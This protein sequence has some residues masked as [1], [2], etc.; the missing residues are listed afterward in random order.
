MKL[1]RKTEIIPYLRMGF[2]AEEVAKKFERSK[3]T[4]ERWIKEL[5]EDGVEVKTIGRGRQ[6]I[7]N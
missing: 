4:V 2:T 1:Y 5:R 3:K 6:R 7:R